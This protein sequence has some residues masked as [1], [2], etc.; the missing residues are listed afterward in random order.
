ML[1][2]LDSADRKTATK[3]VNKLTRK[4]KDLAENDSIDEKSKRNKLE[5]LESRLHTAKVNLNYTIYY[6]LTEKYISI[7]AERKKTGQSQD[8]KQDQDQDGLEDGMDVDEQASGQEGASDA[9]TAEKK[10]M[11]LLVEKC[12]SEGTLDTLREGKLGSDGQDNT[13]VGGGAKKSHVR[14]KKR[15]GK[16]S[17]ENAKSSS[18]KTDN[19]G[20]RSKGSKS[21]PAPAPA[22]ASEDESDGGFFEM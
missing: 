4:Q 14:D 17:A 15:D 18:N 9:V 22:P 3:E 2:Y 1:I 16:D 20:R 12:M 6:P 11:W 8:G 5:K 19:S 10:A 21:A 7:Y 13:S